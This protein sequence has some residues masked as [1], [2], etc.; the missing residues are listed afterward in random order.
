MPEE[1]TLDHVLALK[2]ALT[3][4]QQYVAKIDAPEPHLK[5]GRGR[6]SSVKVETVIYHQA[7]P[8][9]KNYW[10]CDEFDAALVEVIKQNFGD[11]SK[12]ALLLMAGRYQGAY[13]GQKEHL[14]AQL[15]EIE[16]LENEVITITGNISVSGTLT[17]SGPRNVL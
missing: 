10:E 1:K 15:A 9:A 6:L 13:I 7:S 5:D 8:G 16:I 12:K 17:S 14:Q 4:A 11:L 3:D 2:R